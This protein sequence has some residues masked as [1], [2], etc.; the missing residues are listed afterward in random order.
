MPPLHFLVGWEMT[1]EPF[2]ILVGKKR[3]QGKHPRPP[4]PRDPG[5]IA[6]MVFGH[7]ITEGPCL[8]KCCGFTL[9]PRGATCSSIARAEACEPTRETSEMQ[10]LDGCRAPSLPR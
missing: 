3:S 4:G 7:R 8:H 2:I 5:T 9:E 10:H 1:S 6:E